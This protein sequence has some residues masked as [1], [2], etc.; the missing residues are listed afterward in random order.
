METNIANSAPSASDVEAMLNEMLASAGPPV[1]ENATP[2]VEVALPSAEAVASSSAAIA[3]MKAEEESREI[4]VCEIATLIINGVESG[5][6]TKKIA[7]PFEHKRLQVSP[8]KWNQADLVKI[9][10]LILQRTGIDI[11]VK[12]DNVSEKM[13]LF[14]AAQKRVIEHYKQPK[15]ASSKPGKEPK[16]PKAPKAAKEPKV[17]PIVPAPSFATPHVAVELKEDRTKLVPVPDTFYLT[18]DPATVTKRRGHQVDPHRW[19][20]CVPVMPNLDLYHSTG[21]PYPSEPDNTVRASSPEWTNYVKIAHHAFGLLLKRGEIIGHPKELVDEALALAGM[22]AS[23]KYANQAFSD[24][25]ADCALY[26]L[27]DRFLKGRTSVY[28]VK[29]S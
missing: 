14:V 6:A 18:A 26:G 13:P 3:E 27:C 5:L 23:T 22:P 11:G 1:V 9:G 2:V 10:E 24:T 16:A 15:A 8:T 25:F 28:R 29:A 17:V 20:S 21:N 4:A 7:K 12:E 19:A